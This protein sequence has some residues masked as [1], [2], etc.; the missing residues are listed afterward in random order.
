MNDGPDELLHVDDQHGTRVRL[1]VEE[2]RAVH[3]LLMFRLEAMES[4]LP[5]T[6]A[7]IGG[8]LVAAGALPLVSQVVLLVGIPIAVLFWVR[9]IILHAVSKEDAKDRIREIE[10][11]V[12]QIC[13]QPVLRFQSEHP[14]ATG[15]IGGRTGRQMIVLVVVV[16]SVALALCLSLFLVVIDDERFLTL[17]ATGLGVC[18]LGMLHAVIQFTG[19]RTVRIGD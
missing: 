11:E 2:Y 3:Q 19:F 6:A 8:L 5:L 10:R 18:W 16:S 13:G 1:L 12:A 9:G 4:R 17:Y 15:P 14:S 7:G